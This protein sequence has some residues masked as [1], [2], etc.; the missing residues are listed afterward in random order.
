MLRFPAARTAA[1]FDPDKSIAIVADGMGGAACGEIASH[2]TCEVVAERLNN[3]GQDA[4]VELL[5]DAIREANARVLERARS[6]RSCK[7]MGSTIVAACWEL[8]RVWVAN[9]GDSRAYLHRQGVLQQLTHDQTLVNELRERMGLTQEEVA[10]F[11]HKN[12][13]TMAIG[14]TDDLVVRIAEAEFVNGDH[15][16]LCSDG[17]TGPVPENTIANLLD[18]DIPLDEKVRELISAAKHHGAPDNV[19]VVL[20]RYHA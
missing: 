7:G 8:P 4:S 13:L 17:L 20:L 1:W 3:S 5:E 12:V 19:T 15:L 16:L 14:S 10:N 2:I 6:E 18:R 11:P 9:V